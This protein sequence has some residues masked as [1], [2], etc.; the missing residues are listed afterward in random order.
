MLV[1]GFNFQNAKLAYINVRYA[2]YDIISR[3][4]YDA[5]AMIGMC[6]GAG[7]KVQSGNIGCKRLHRR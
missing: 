2:T 4:F 1:K 5:Q 6:D 7:Q 3:V